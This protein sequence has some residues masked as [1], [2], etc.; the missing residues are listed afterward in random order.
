MSIDALYDHRVKAGA[1]GEDEVTAACK[2]QVDLPRLEVVGQAQEVLGGIDDIARDAE[3]PADDVRRAAGEHRHRDVGAG[4]SVCD[5]VEG[6]V[7]A[8]CDDDVVAAVDRF[9]ADLRGM[10]LRLGHDRLDLVAALEGVDD[11]VLQSVRDRCRI[12][13]DDDQHALL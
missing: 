8:E 13:V 11:E 4:E 3:A 12:R 6:P 5:L 7:A 10:V 1:A 9:A 2:T